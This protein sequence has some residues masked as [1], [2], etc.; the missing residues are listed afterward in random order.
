[1]RSVALAFL[2]LFPV[3]AF[4]CN[5]PQQNTQAKPTLRG[6]VTDQTGA[7][8]PGA[9]VQLLDAAGTVAATVRSSGDG[10]FMVIAPRPG[11]FTLVVTLAGFKTSRSQVTVGVPG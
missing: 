9:D 4:A 8:I 5:P 2:L 1:M 11:S 7:I 6:L 3:A 10:S